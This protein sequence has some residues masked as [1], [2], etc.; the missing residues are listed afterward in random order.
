MS[1]QFFTDAIYISPGA[2]S[3][4]YRTRDELPA[5]VDPEARLNK[6]EATQDAHARAIAILDAAVGASTTIGKRTVGYQ[7]EDDDPDSDTDPRGERSRVQG[8][9]ARQDKY[10]NGPNKRVSDADVDIPRRPPSP[11]DINEANAKA[12]RRDK[13]SMTGGSGSLSPNS[14]EAETDPAYLPNG[15]GSINVEGRKST[16]APTLNRGQ[17]W[18]TSDMRMMQ[19]ACAT[20]DA[21]TVSTLQW[22]NAANLARY[23][24]DKR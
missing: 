9:L 3:K 22:M 6:L 17:T 21:R 1:R 20:Q 13:S 8:M 11:S 18:G 4:G 7:I 23:R 12:W 15:T 14:R 10:D 5:R 19:V 16:T 2:R 24:N